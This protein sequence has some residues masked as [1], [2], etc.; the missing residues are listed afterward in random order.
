MLYVGRPHLHWT[1]MRFWKECCIPIGGE[2]QGI[3]SEGINFDRHYDYG[4]AVI[5]FGVPFQYTLLHLSSLLFIRYYC[6]V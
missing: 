1:S 4:R 5:M 3:V 6:S 2:G